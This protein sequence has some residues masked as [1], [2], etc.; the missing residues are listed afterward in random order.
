[1]TEPSLCQRCYCLNGG[2]VWLSWTSTRP[3]LCLRDSGPVADGRSSGIPWR[4]Q[5][6]VDVIPPTENPELRQQY[7]MLL[8]ELLASAEYALVTQRDAYVPL[9]RS[10]SQ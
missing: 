1:M 5:R 10:R 3:T 7:Q 8:T 4:R 6:V 2:S 9:R